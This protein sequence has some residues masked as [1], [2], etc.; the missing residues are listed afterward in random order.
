MAT[1]RDM[2]A[3][4]VLRFHDAAT[5]GLDRVV[6]RLN[7]I[8][9]AARRLTM[10]A[11]AI[12]AIGSI[13]FAG[14]ARSAAQLEA[15]IRDIGITAE[16]SGASLRTF[17]DQ[18]RHD[19]FRLARDNRVASREL[20]GAEGVLAARNLPPAFIAQMRRVSAS[21]IGATGMAGTDLGQL[22]TSYYEMGGLRTPE[23]MY[24]AIGRS[25]AAGQIGGFE[26]QNMARYMPSVMAQGPVIGMS[27]DRLINVGLAALQTVRSGAGTTEETVAALQQGFGHMYAEQTIRRMRDLGVDMHAVYRNATRRMNAGENTDPFRAGLQAM[28][29][30]LLAGGPTAASLIPDQNT[31]QAYLAIIQNAPRFNQFLR[32]ISAATPRRMERAHGDRSQGLG[33]EMRTIDENLTQ[34]GDRLGM[35]VEGPLT[36]IN[37]GLA[38]LIQHIGAL[39][40]RYPGMIDQTVAWGAGITVAAVGVG[41]LGQAVG[42]LA[43]GI[44]VLLAPLAWAIGAIVGVIGIKVAIIIGVIAAL[45][46]GAYALWRYWDRLGPWFSGLWD[47]VKGYFTGFVAWVDGWT[48]GA[49]SQA[50]AAIET[51]WTVLSTWFDTLWNQV[52]RTAFTGFVAWVDSWTGGVMSQ[53]INNIMAPWRALTGF[54]GALWNDIEGT[55]NRV[56][57]P[58]VATV[59]EVATL[60]GR[61]R[62]DG[63]PRMADGAQI[64]R[65]SAL[66][67][68]R[69]IEGDDDPSL[70]EQSRAP[71]APAVGIS[72]APWRA[73]LVIR[74]APG[75]E[76]VQ[77]QSSDPRV[78]ISR[79]NRGPSYGLP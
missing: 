6:G 12:A 39:D 5:A 18:A 2:R 46:A 35:A 48:G 21:A 63:T 60:V 25:F 55:F 47:T 17:V 7:R 77:T 64:S 23:Q 69:R 66:T 43:S 14:P 62:G 32:D 59:R 61:I 38:E 79:P 65:R 57:G 45:A 9:Q 50:I 10:A 42:V 41:L 40:A 22:I 67:G 20:I 72:P 3:S 29:P 1:G 15:Q 4:L 75:T 73:E 31:R 8:N 26:M 51:A 16:H 28:R 30:F 11:G 44:R 52:I 34:I 54:F 76:V 24:Q 58:I 13:T 53:A 49:M 27:G 78:Q 19:L 37:S 33:A 68:V 36:R 74:A 70:A 71:W 56:V